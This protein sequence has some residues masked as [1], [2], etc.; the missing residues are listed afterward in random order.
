M[1]YTEISHKGPVNTAK[2]Y[3]EGDVVSLKVVGYDEEKKRL[4]FSIKAVTQ[5]PWQE[6][7]K[8]CKGLYDQGGCKQY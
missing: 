4:S 8:S 5:D 1:H 6:V 2:L 3:K 7:Q